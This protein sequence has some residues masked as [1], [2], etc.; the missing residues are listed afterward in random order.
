MTFQPRAFK[1]LADRVKE[2][3]WEGP[4]LRP[5]LISTFGTALA[6]LAP[7][8]KRDLACQLCD[9]EAPWVDLGGRSREQ[10]GAPG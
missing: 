5:S 6:T 2:P 7:V 4:P 1:K 8:P 3:S 9:A 10:S